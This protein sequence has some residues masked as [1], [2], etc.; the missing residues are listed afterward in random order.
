[1]SNSSL[2]IESLAFEIMKNLD[3]INSEN[4]ENHLSDEYHA[5]AQSFPLYGFIGRIITCS[6]DKYVIIFEFQ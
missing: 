1:M 4:S 6:F 2:L 3:F 5:C